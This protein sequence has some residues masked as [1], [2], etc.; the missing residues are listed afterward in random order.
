MQYQTLYAEM[1]GA[2]ERAIE[3]IEQDNY[4]QAK[5][6]LIDAEQRC[7]AQYLDAPEPPAAP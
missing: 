1:V 6:I 5:Q 4:G 3:A 2:A 7:E